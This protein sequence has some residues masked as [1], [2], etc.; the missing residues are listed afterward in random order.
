MEQA[1]M[2]NKLNANIE[3]MKAWTHA[4]M[5]VADV[6][7]PA[8]AAIQRHIDTLMDNYARILGLSVDEIGRIN[9]DQDRWRRAG[10]WWAKG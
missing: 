6:D 10:E 4:L 7:S 1:A 8:A 2:L 5:R 3:E 9:E